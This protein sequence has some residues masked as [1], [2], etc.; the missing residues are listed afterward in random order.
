M[1]AVF[2]L[3]EGMVMAQQDDVPILRPKNQATKPASA[4]LLVT[5]D[6]ACD[7]TLD[8]DAKGRIETGGS[9]K[10][11]VELGQHIVIAVTEDGADHV[12]QLSE[13]KSSGQTAMSIEL[14]PVRDAR[15]KGEQDAR[16]KVEREAKERSEKEARDKTERETRERAEQDA[17]DKAAKEAQAKTGRDARERVE[18]ETR[19]KAAREQAERDEAAG[20]TWTDPATGLTWTKKDNGFDVYWDGAARIC[21]DLDLGGHTDWRLPTIDELAGIY[22]S[23]QRTHGH[24]IKGKIRLTGC[25]SCLE[26]LWSNTPSNSYGGERLFNFDL[27]ERLAYPKYEDHGVRAL[28]VRR[29]RE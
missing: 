27:G 18:Q 2:A 20:L 23:T 4:I 21:R 1:I 28:C 14:Q 24:H 11:K 6:L 13:V 25:Y 16:D 22:D 12:R 3:G 9:A 15:L 17:R 19:D 7:W 29:T 10:V 8:G 5:C 26:S